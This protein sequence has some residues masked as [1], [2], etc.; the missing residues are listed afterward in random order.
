[1]KGEAG[2]ERAVIVIFESEQYLMDFY[3]DPQFE[4]L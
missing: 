4:S 3:E 2:G 1:M